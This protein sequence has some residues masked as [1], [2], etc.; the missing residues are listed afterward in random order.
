M[1]NPNKSFKITI[2]DN[3]DGSVLVDYDNA[4]A[5][6]GAISANGG[7]HSIGY[8][9]C[10]AITLAQAIGGCQ[11]VIAEFIEDHPELNFIAQMIA[12]MEAAGIGDD[13]EGDG[14]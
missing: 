9:A 11:K 4:Q 13:E 5:I 10:N 7:T 8:T 6:I 12:Q 2:I 3:E 1:S 14:E